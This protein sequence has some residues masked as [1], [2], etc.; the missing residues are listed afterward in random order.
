VEEGEEKEEEEERKE[1]KGHLLLLPIFVM[2]EDTRARWR[3]GSMCVPVCNEWRGK[4]GDCGLPEGRI[5]C[6]R[7]GSD[8]EAK[9]IATRDLD[10]MKE[11]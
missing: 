7:E 8:N 4:W 3:V 9:R 10:P 6:F 2:I 11:G 5:A 1:G